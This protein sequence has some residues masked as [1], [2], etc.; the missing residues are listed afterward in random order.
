MRTRRGGPGQRP[1]RVAQRY[2]RMRRLP[3]DVGRPHGTHRPDDSASTQRLNRI[4]SGMRSFRGN[5]DLRSSLHHCSQWLRRHCMAVEH[6]AGAGKIRKSLTRLR[7]KRVGINF[8]FDPP[9]QWQWRCTAPRGAGGSGVEAHWR[10]G[11][12]GAEQINTVCYLLR[13]ARDRLI[14]HSVN[15]APCCRVGRNSSKRRG[16]GGGGRHGKDEGGGDTTQERPPTLSL[17]GA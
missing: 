17:T 9:G 2:V 4:A 7:Y 13:P 10:R 15:K 8:D 1:W 14:R 5:P 11:E 6:S 16:E 12:G 3:A